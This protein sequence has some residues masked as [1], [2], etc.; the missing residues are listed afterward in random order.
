MVVA[1]DADDRG[2]GDEPF[3]PPGQFAG[4][5]IAPEEIAG[6]ALRK[7]EAVTRGE[8]AL[9]IGPSEPSEDQDF[10]QI[11]ERQQRR[12]AHD[13]LHQERNA[14]GV[15][16]HADIREPRT[17]ALDPYDRVR[18]ARVLV[19][20]MG[21]VMLCEA[22]IETLPTSCQG[23]Q[24]GLSPA[25]PAIYGNVIVEPKLSAGL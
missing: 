20:S 17:N 21:A 7:G 18:R 6:F 5:A 13:V 12:P 24:N 2:L 4:A 19:A 10:R 9:G 23:E 14:L 11:D 15:I 1:T 8:R 22:T 16:D 25:I 3:G